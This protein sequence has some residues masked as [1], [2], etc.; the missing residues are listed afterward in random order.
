MHFV[1]MGHVGVGARLPGGPKQDGYVKSELCRNYVR[2]ARNR[3]RIPTFT[4]HIE[5]H[6]VAGSR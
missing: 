5:P 1:A 6:S 4:V 2:W 3:R